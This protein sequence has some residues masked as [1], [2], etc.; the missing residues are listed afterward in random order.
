[1]C[2][3]QWYNIEDTNINSKFYL[4]EFSMRIKGLDDYVNRN[5]SPR[6]MYILFFDVEIVSKYYYYS[7][8]SN[9]KM[10]K[11]TNKLEKIFF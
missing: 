3:C 11:I 4:P 5:R 9:V 8:F 1:M 2:T 10:L 6:I 7:F